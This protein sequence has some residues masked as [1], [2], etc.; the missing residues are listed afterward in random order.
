MS[1]YI[2]EFI[3]KLGV[4]CR[5]A[6]YAGWGMEVSRDWGMTNASTIRKT[7]TRKTNTGR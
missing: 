1:I 3:G 4:E 5:T 6:I 7:W 2:Y